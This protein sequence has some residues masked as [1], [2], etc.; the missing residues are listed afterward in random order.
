[1]EGMWAKREDECK[2]GWEVSVG[3]KRERVREEGREWGQV[4]EGGRD[5]TKGRVTKMI[6]IRSILETGRLFAIEH[7]SS[8]HKQGRDH[9]EAP[10]CE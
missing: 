9:W 4:E 2:R 3:R 7:T 8:K 1:M 10:V 5:E 6:D